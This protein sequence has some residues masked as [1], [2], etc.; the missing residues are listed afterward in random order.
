MVPGRGRSTVLSPKGHDFVAQGNALVTEHP[1]NTTRPERAGLD[2]FGPFRAI[3][4]SEFP[5]PRALPWATELQPFGLDGIGLGY[6]VAA[7]RAGKLGG[8]Q[9]ASW[10][11]PGTGLRTHV[12]PVS[13]QR[14]LAAAR[15]RFKNRRYPTNVPVVPDEFPPLRLCVSAVPTPS[16]PV[17]DPARTR[18]IRPETGGSTHKCRSRRPSPRCGCRGCRKRGSRP[19]GPTCATPRARFPG[20]RCR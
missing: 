4:L 3:G 12:I 7:L 18:I 5:V 6:R 2:L 19:S 16:G 10:C 20:V 17:S 13:S 9:R 1:E 8:T 11:R 15:Y 14:P